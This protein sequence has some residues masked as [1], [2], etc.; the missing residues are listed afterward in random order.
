MWNIYNSSDYAKITVGD[1]VSHKQYK[2]HG[3]MTVNGINFG[4]AE[5]ERADGTITYYTISELELLSEDFGT[6]NLKEDP[7]FCSCTRS[8]AKIVESSIQVQGSVDSK[9]KFRFCRTCKK[10]AK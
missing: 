2:F 6:A 7:L 5:L 9:D 10:E 1:K 4:T 3:K 8:E